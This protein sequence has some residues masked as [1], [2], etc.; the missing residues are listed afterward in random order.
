MGYIFIAVGNPEEHVDYISHLD[1]LNRNKFGMLK[2]CTHYIPI[3]IQIE[4]KIIENKI[5]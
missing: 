2:Y 4:N 1:Y 5:K 3:N